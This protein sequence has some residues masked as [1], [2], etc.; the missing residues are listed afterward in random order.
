MHELC[1]KDQTC[2]SVSHL[3]ALTGV[4]AIMEAGGHIAAH[5]AQ[6][7][8]AI[9][10]CKNKMELIICVR[11]IRCERLVQQHKTVLCLLVMLLLVDVEERP[12]F[13][14]PWLRWWPLLAGG[15]MSTTMPTA[16]LGSEG[17]GKVGDVDR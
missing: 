1:S 2:G 15:E 8:H 3:A 5:F 13:S 16:L 17:R 6:Q 11:R 4:N 10:F 12:A 9:D 14:M 7:H